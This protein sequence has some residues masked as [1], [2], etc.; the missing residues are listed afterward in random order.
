M[1]LADYLRGKQ[2]EAEAVITSDCDSSSVEISSERRPAR[3]RKVQ[4]TKLNAKPDDFLKKS[5][6]S[7]TD[8]TESES[9]QDG[10]VDQL[11]VPSGSLFSG[12]V[13]RMNSIIRVH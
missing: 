2:A 1:I 3:K 9:D 5:K 10:S 11:E 13:M 6:E 8:E 4:T 12:K 7:S